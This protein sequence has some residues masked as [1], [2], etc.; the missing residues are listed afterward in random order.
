[1]GVPIIFLII[2]P[3]AGII[4]MQLTPPFSRLAVVLSLIFSFC[5]LVLLYRYLL[6]PLRTVVAALAQPGCAEIPSIPTACDVVRALED[7][8]NAREATLRH[9]LA[10]ARETAA[11]LRQEIQE[12]RERRVVDMQT[13][14]TA[15]AALRKAQSE[16]NDLATAADAGSVLPV[17]RPHITE[18]ILDLSA[19]L[20]HSECILLHASQLLGTADTDKDE[21][22]TTL[23]EAFPWDSRYNTNIP[24]IDGQHKLLLSYINKLHRGMQKGCD[25]SLLLEILDDLTG[26]AFSHFATEEIFFSRT[27]YPL[28]ARHIEVHQS[29]RKTVTELR[30]AVLDDKA[31]IDIALLEYLKT[32]LVDHIQ[33]MDVGFASYVTGTKPTPE[34]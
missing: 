10:E 3:L 33:Q 22:D 1:M 26:Y 19:V 29:F 5:G 28:T 7:S 20:H 15:L 17:D 2:A 24:V 30:E 4:A 16:L 34:Q 32:W 27:A 13:Q 8:L 9:D 6:L 12:L 18:Q 25:K 11:K 31:F 14:Q 21:A 23:A